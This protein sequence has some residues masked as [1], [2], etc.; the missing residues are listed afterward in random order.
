MKNRSHS[1]LTEAEQGFGYT[2][3]YMWESLLATYGGFSAGRG[4]TSGEVCS[5]ASRLR[6]KASRRATL[7]ACRRTVSTSAFFS[8]ASCAPASACC[9]ACARG[10]R[11][12]GQPAACQALGCEEHRMCQCHVLHAELSVRLRAYVHSCGKPRWAHACLARPACSH[13]QRHKLGG[14]HAL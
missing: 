14:A 5:V 13:A 8:A 4:R 3:G 6:R 12:C 2:I 11:Q 7:A 9:R 10:P 1:K